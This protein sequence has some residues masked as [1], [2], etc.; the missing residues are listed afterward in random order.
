[1]LRRISW[2]LFGS[3]SSL[4]TNWA[5]QRKSQRLS[6]ARAKGT[7]SVASLRRPILCHVFKAKSLA[8]RRTLAVYSHVR[9]NGWEHQ[10]PLPHLVN[11][12]SRGTDTFIWFERF[13][14]DSSKQ[15]GLPLSEFQ[16]LR[17]ESTKV[18]VDHGFSKTAISR[19]RKNWC[20]ANRPGNVK[21]WAV[22]IDVGRCALT[23]KAIKAD[24][25]LRRQ[26]RR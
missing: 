14:L 4:T 23:D 19:H 20:I 17:D 9:E 13:G 2:R 6:S 24:A 22:L 21:C 12:E 8:C 16:A 1:M 18:L 15:K 5:A 25:R 3:T 7:R 26:L 11:S 10:L